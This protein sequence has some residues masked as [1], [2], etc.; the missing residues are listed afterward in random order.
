MIDLICFV[1]TTLTRWKSCKPFRKGY[2]TTKDKEY[3]GIG[4]DLYTLAIGADSELSTKNQL[5]KMWTRVE[6]R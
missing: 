1:A 5:V 4:L 6:T 2:R 3:Q